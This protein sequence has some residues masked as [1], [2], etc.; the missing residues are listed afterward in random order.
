MNS[1]KT[2]FFENRLELL[3]IFT[4]LCLN[5]QRFDYTTVQR[6][7]RI[8]LL[9]LI[10]SL[11][12]VGSLN[13]TLLRFIDHEEEKENKT[14]SRL[15]TVVFVLGLYGLLTQREPPSL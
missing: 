11:S 1:Y 3:S 15:T 9:R 5:I 7:T 12:L 6:L 10:S 2:V 8:F 13:S 14:S 4:L